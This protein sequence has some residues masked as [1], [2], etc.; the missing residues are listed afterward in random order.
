MGEKW[1]RQREKRW[2][3]FSFRFAS[4]DAESGSGGMAEERMVAL[5]G[6]LRMEIEVGM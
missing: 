3:I 2:H 6:G 5:Q 1:W 4:L